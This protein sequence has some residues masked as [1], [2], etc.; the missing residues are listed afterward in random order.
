MDYEKEFN[1]SQQ[2][3]IRPAARTPLERVWRAGLW[4]AAIGLIFA[5]AAANPSAVG[6]AWRKIQ[7][8]VAPGS[9]PPANPSAPVDNSDRWIERL[10]HL[11]PQA[12]AE[13]LAEQA[14]RNRP[15]AA[16]ILSQRAGQ[17]DG[18][19]ALSPRLSDLLRSDVNSNDTAVRAAALDTYL[20]AYNVPKSPAGAAS[21]K[22]RISAEPAA[23]PWALWALGALGNRGVEQPQ[24]FATL[25]VYARDPDQQVRIW[26]VEGLGNLGSDE[27]IEA[28]LDVLRSDPSSKVK[29]RAASNLAQ[30]GML[31]HDQ[32]M[33]AVPALVGMAGDA[34]F[35]V[36]THLWI[37]QALMD[38]TGEHYGNNLDAWRKWLARRTAPSPS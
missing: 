23:R 6:G 38:I 22:K 33:K 27:T 10:A 19:I 15:Q 5:I 2:G 25:S 28:L 30:S 26:A 11:P 20:A 36:P 34:S 37:F 7:N 21:I 24:A 1:A 4:C 18:K 9:A 29:E 13:L 16:A 14:A 17:W 31:S 35:D 12:Q 3:P 8:I 32:R